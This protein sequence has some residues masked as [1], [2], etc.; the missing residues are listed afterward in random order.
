[1]GTPDCPALAATQAAVAAHTSSPWTWETNEQAQITMKKHKTII[2][3]ALNDK[4]STQEHCKKTC[5]EILNT[6]H[7]NTALKKQEIILAGIKD[8]SQIGG[9]E[10]KQHNATGWT[11]LKV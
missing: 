4:K 9:S 8:A 2:L 1:M 5:K 7:H 6:T 3:S 10:T 11:R